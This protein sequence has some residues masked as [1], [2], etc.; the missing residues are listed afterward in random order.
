MA[1]ELEDADILK[2]AT[3]CRTLFEEGQIALADSAADDA[4]STDAAA[5]D[6][7]DDSSEWAK[8]DECDDPRF[9]GTGM[10][11]NPVDADIGRDATDC[12][13]A[14][15]AG[16]VTLA[17]NQP[18]SGNGGSDASSVFAAIAT[19]IDFGDDS[20]DFPNDGEC[21]DPDFVGFHQRDVDLA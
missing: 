9:A 21:D 12:E 20:G 15:A 16:T 14:F 6:F 7:G 19:R 18:Q 11:E 4:S 8:D 13:A 5:I 2:D 3:D 1:A 10:A 17:E